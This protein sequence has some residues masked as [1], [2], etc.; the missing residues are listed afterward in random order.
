[1][2][3]AT[4]IHDEL[5]AKYIAGE[6]DATERAEVEAWMS[7]S[8]ANASELERMRSVWNW[9]GEGGLVPEVDTDAAWRKVNARITGSSRGRVIPLRRWLAVAA[10]LT[11][12]VFAVRWFFTPPREVF[13]SDRGYRSVRLADSSAVV[14]SPGTRLA[15]VMR[16]E[17]DVQLTGEAYFAVQ[18]D[19]S[20]PFV[21][22]TTDVDVTV[23][24][25]EFTV[26]AYDTAR[27]VQVRVR[28]GR[29]QVV[30][31]PDTLVLAAGEHARFDRQ[32]HVLERA[33]AP[34]MEVWGE[35]ILQ[36]EN[37]PLGDVMRQLERLY[38]VHIALGREALGRCR[39]TATFE[40]EPVDRI[41]QV[42]AD[43]Y[44][45]RVSRS[46]DNSYTLDGEGCE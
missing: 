23:L 2:N 28:E 29:V 7:A 33:P 20:H 21:I 19:V 40:E 36:F 34:P 10:V 42:I 37:A 1:M 43:T 17:R 15:A 35:R 25:T 12:L 6:A 46:S 9:S 32:R 11:G 22:H 41:L 3:G 38:T 45:L 13:A 4:P 30:A 27:A 24:G 26:S 31:G 44:G 18:R 8:P 16:T 14:L 39:L 5:L